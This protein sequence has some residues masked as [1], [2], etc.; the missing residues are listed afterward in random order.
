MRGIEKREFF[1]ID[2][3]AEREVPSVSFGTAPA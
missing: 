1:E 2:A 3:P